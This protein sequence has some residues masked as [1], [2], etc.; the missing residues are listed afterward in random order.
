[1]I[2]AVRVAAVYRIGAFGS[3]FVTLELLMAGWGIAEAYA[4][5]ACNLFSVGKQHQGPV[6][7][8]NQDT[9]R[10]GACRHDGRIVLRVAAAAC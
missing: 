1:M 6:T 10:L 8:V 9:V 7:L 3:L 5:I 4:V 2:A